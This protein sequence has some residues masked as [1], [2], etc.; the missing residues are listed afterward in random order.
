MS[1]QVNESYML[2]LLK[3]LLDT[4]SPS[5]FTHHIIA[6]IEEEAAKLGVTTERNA[7]GGAVLRLKGEDSS[8]PL[9]LSA[10]V[11]TLLCGLLLR[12]EPWLLH[13]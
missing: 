4:P 9:C 12:A 3:K 2:T 13:P 5:G 8:S 6:M 1:I 7:K 11:D 10:H